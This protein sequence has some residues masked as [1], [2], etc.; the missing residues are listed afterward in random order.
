MSLV[1]FLA[2]LADGKIVPAVA[3]VVVTTTVVDNGVTPAGPYVHPFAPPAPASRAVVTAS[4]ITETKDAIQHAVYDVALACGLATTADDMRACAMPHMPPALA[5][6]PNVYAQ[7]VCAAMDLVAENADGGIQHE[8]VYSTARD[9]IVT[10]TP[11]LVGT[12]YGAILNYAVTLAWPAMTAHPVTSVFA[13]SIGAVAARYAEFDQY[14]AWIASSPLAMGNI[15][16]ARVDALFFD[17]S[18]GGLRPTARIAMDAVARCSGVDALPLPPGAVERYRTGYASTSAD[19]SRTDTTWL[20]TLADMAVVAGN[21]HVTAI[22]DRVEFARVA[23]VTT[24]ALQNDARRKD[25]GDLATRAGILHAGANAT[26]RLVGKI[27]TGGGSVVDAYTL[28]THILVYLAGII[29]TVTLTQ[30]LRLTGSVIR[31]TT[32][33]CLNALRA[34]LSN[35]D[36]DRP[37]PPPYASV[38]AHARSQLDPYIATADEDDEDAN[39]AVVASALLDMAYILRSEPRTR[40]AIASLYAYIGGG[41]GGD[42]YDILRAGLENTIGA[43]APPTRPEPFGFGVSKSVS[44]RLRAAVSTVRWAV[45]P[46]HNH[47]PRHRAAALVA[48][49]ML[50]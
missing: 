4:T 16:A 29:G 46:P 25:G 2:N 33:G 32:R 10:A 5:D 3:P 20:T 42:A 36:D 27:A 26:A 47:R 48:A 37:A 11:A 17:R 35:D 38:T 23:T 21:D 6:D 41:G 40:R 31:A 9:I 24:A 44:E 22:E 50:I 30:A 45:P 18:T 49:L 1:Y 43:A 8:R 34:G 12:A 19:L 14:G 15:A 28:Y 13:L 7:V 39:P